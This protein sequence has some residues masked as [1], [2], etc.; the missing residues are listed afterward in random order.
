M[1]DSKDFSFTYAGIHP[2]EPLPAQTS[3]HL[4]DLTALADT[5]GMELGA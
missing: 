4:V 1:N 3:V 5:I 2:E